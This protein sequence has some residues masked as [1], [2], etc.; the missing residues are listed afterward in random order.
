[1]E[2]RT[3]RGWKLIA[4]LAA[5]VVVGGW[6]VVA[7]TRLEFQPQTKITIQGT[8]TM[9]DFEC[10]A[11]AVA[12]TLE[13]P[14]TDVPDVGKM[15]GGLQAVSVTVPV[16]KIDC[17]NGTMDKKMR[18]ALA[19]KKAPLIKYTLSTASLKGSADASGYYP[20]VAK[21][22]LT[23]AGNDRPIELSV[24]GKQMPDGRFQFTGSKQIKM[25]DWGVKPP[26]AMLGTMK[27]GDEVTVHFEVIAANF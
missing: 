26:T 21:G 14:T 3:N 25:S 10:T 4:A 7:P 12:G 20:M 18:E 27:T 15:L 8:S 19:E 1:M 6:M 13:L 17:G 22:S 11:A 24:K 23:I 2:Q 16:S 9:H 5:T